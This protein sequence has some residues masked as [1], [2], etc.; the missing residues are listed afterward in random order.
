MKPQNNFSSIPRFNTKTFRSNSETQ[1][2]DS[3]ILWAVVIITSR[4]CSWRPVFF[5]IPLFY[6]FFFCLAIDTHLDLKQ[7]SSTLPNS[8]GRRILHL[9]SSNVII[10]YLI[11]FISLYFT[12][13]HL[14]TLRTSS[15]LLFSEFS[16]LCGLQGPKTETTASTATRR[17]LCRSF[18]KRLALEEHEVYE[19]HWTARFSVR[20]LPYHVPWDKRYCDNSHVNAV[21]CGQWI[22]RCTSC[23]WQW[24]TFEW[25][26]VSPAVQSWK[27][28]KTVWDM[29]TQDFYRRFTNCLPHLHSNFPKQDQQKGMDGHATRFEPPD[30]RTHL[31]CSSLKLFFHL[32]LRPKET[33]KDSLN[34]DIQRSWFMIHQ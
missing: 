10:L 14:L 20:H 32:H 18:S 30:P 4:P 12:I 17:S 27:K 26:L 25:L 31:F 33:K 28:A 13:L 7:D 21:R 29:F 16:Y 6:S 34:R 3:S 24:H 5:G 22:C 2:R 19:V 1:I 23:F 11:N 8:R 15:I 9:T